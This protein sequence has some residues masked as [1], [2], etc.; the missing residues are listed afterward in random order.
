MFLKRGRVTKTVKMT[1]TFYN[2]YFSIFLKT[3]CIDNLDP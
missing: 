3:I 1:V 2:N